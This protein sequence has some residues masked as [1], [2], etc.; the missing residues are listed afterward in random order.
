M[1]GAAKQRVKKER[2]HP[3]MSAET[4]ATNGASS[5]AATSTTELN[6]VTELLASTSI[7]DLQSAGYRQILDVVDRLRTCGLGSILPLPQL[8]VCGNQSSGK[9]SV[10]EAI[11]EVPF[12]RK[13]SLCTRFA[14]EIILR[15]DQSESL[16]TKI[17]PDESRPEAEKM[18]LKNFSETITDFRQL[19]RLIDAATELMGLNA[20][21]HDENSTKAFTRDVLSVE[22]AGPGRPQLT[23]VDLPGLIAAP[24]QMQT[25][26]DVA[27]I[28]SLVEDYLKEKR[29]I[30]LAVIS[31]KDD[32]ANQGI[33]KK[34]KAVDKD[35]H[36]TLGIITKPDYLRAG[37]PN[38]NL[39]I[40]LARNKNIYFEL[41]W[42]ML[43]NRSD[44]E[45][46]SSFEARNSSEKAFFNAG[47]YRTLPDHDKGVD[48]L[49]AKL[50]KLLF[51]HLKK[52]LPN[53]QAELNTKHHKTLDDLHALG[54]A[55]STTAEQKRFLMG[56]AT[57]YQ[58]IVSSAVNGNYDHSFFGHINPK[59]GFDDPA[60]W[61]RIRAA[62]QHLNLKFASQMRQYGHKYRIWAM[63]GMAGTNSKRDPPE[64]DL[65][66]YGAV[67]DLQI[68]MT[69]PAAVQ[70]VKCIL[71]RTRGRELPGNFNPLLMS[72]L[73]WEQ[74]ENWERLAVEHI[75][76]VDALCDAFVRTAIQH[77]TP[78][79]VA[80]RLQ[81]R[82][83]E[84]MK[85]RH[86]DAVAELSR[87][88]ADKQRPPI[89]YDPAYTAS[90]QES[91][92]QKATAKYQELLESAQY[93]VPSSEE[94][95]APK[96]MMVN[97]E[98]LKKELKE[99]IE[100]DMDKTSAEDALDSQLAYY[101]D[102]VKIFIAAVTKQV[103]ERHLLHHLAEATLSPLLINDMSE[104]EVAYLAAE[105][106]ESVHMREF[107][108]GHKAILESGREAFRG[109]LGGF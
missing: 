52:E 50:S 68:E 94:Q 41:G 38:E 63:D 104:A 1:A 16:R 53:F 19:P 36:R 58:S 100:P 57:S 6:R 108:Q 93:H 28:H 106:E 81:G 4:P 44:E 59:E 49:R 65:E 11:T 10:L 31:A 69:R 74:S 37:S 26:A 91:R 88:I 80:T 21:S 13:E 105:A 51:R 83:G 39:W 75:A 98:V 29:T 22:I 71:V 77:V 20:D 76:N 43:K 32:F 109:V 90:M 2:V 54:E 56:I 17:I 62:V 89:T 30:M 55:R 64:P 23:L 27:L 78:P 35:G 79:E 15:R 67:K 107:L 24:N 101:K 96:Q 70:W 7:D 45:I 84:A 60:N 82:I 103:I 95:G 9:S 40:D 73:F 92:S 18:N 66:D 85:Q 48:S 14:T 102:E 46:D 87:L 33:L 99:L 42:H 47:Q 25:D 86:T 97:A 61:C 8:V 34:C 12:P 3:N 5:E 72:Q